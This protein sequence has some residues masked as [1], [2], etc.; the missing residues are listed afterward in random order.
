MTL[1]V[2]FPSAP[3][4]GHTADAAAVE[5]TTGKCSERTLLCLIEV[6]DANLLSVQRF[7]Q[8]TWFQSSCTER[9]VKFL[10]PQCFRAGRQTTV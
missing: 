5:N 6:A 7:S 1:T 10:M 3:E 4:E 2:F 8:F 9:V